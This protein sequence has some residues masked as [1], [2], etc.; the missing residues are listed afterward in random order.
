MNFAIDE[1]NIFGKCFSNFPAIGERDGTLIIPSRDA[2]MRSTHATTSNEKQKNK[3]S[4]HPKPK[5]HI[6]QRIGCWIKYLCHHP[7]AN[8]FAH[9]AQPKSRWPAVHLKR[10]VPKESKVIL[11]EAL[12]FLIFHSHTPAMTIMVHSFIMLSGLLL[13]WPSMFIITVNTT[14]GNETTFRNGQWINGRA[15][16]KVIYAY[17]KTWQRYC[18][19]RNSWGDALVAPCLHH[20]QT[21]RVWNNVQWLVHLRCELAKNSSL[22]IGYRY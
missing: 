7:L 13:W 16:F 15:L 3:I 21:N 5:K 11:S 17:R 14:E 6:S 22:R 4:N 19:V 2:R 9:N 12:S 1:G 18:R 10:F 8:C 20:Y